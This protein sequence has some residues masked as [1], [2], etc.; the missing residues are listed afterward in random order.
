MYSICQYVFFHTVK[1]F[2]KIKNPGLAGILLFLM[3][4]VAF[5]L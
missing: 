4:F 2:W 3:K 1:K 5:S